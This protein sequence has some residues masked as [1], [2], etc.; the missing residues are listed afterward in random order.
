MT[1]HIV[2][3]A[4]YK[5][6]QLDRLKQRRNQL[7]TLCT[8]A[9]L[10]GTILL[11]HE[12]INLFVA[13]CRHGI[14]GLLRELR[15][16]P[17]LADL[18][19]KESLSNYQPFNRMLVRLKQEIIAFGVPGIAPAQATSPKLSAREL[20][21]WL[22]EGRPLTLLDVR[23]DYEVKLGTFKQAQPIGV[24]HF[25]DFPEAVKKLPPEAKQQPLVMFCTGGIRCEK[26]GPLMEREGFE[27]VYQ[28]DGGILKYFEECGGAHYEGDCFVFDQRVTVDCQ[29]RET[30][31][32]QC[33][34]C[35]ASLSEADQQ[36]EKYVVGESC[37]Y[38]FQTPAEK[39][40]AAIAGR[41]AAI[42]ALCDP[43]PGSV[44]YDNARPLNV[45][46]R[47]DQMTLLDFLD[48]FHPQV[49]RE[50]WRAACAAGAIVDRQG[51][52][53]EDR[54]VRAGE[55]FDHLQPATVE[56]DVNAD[57]QILHEDDALVVVNKPAPLPMHPS[58]R[59]HRNTL[60]Y[61]LNRV[62]EP[63]RL[64]A[65]HRLDANTSG[66]VIFSRTR[67]I[68]ARVQPQF[69]SG[70]VA[71]IYVA[72]IA[73]HPCDDHF[74]ATVPI[75]A[76]PSRTG[77]RLPDVSGSPARTEFRVLRRDEDGTALLDVHPLTGRTNQI[78]VHLWDLGMPVVGDPVYLSG[79]KLGDTQ[80]VTTSCTPLCLHAWTV[81]LQHPF[82]NERVEFETP[83]PAWFT[84]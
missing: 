34:A 66:V 62:Y 72:R 32:K 61:I 56:P 14:D 31:T 53:G 43:L 69:E 38:C 3:I 21:R 74:V 12:G 23:N 10:K 64:R 58:G 81:A 80:T 78:R 35:Q 9:G 83:L 76:S 36:S 33:F 57:I 75:S 27:Q 6:V 42:R 79:R 54:I 55:R 5:F 77:A 63:L 11:S 16:D 13:G 82:T 37:P 25:R 8:E 48:A 20:K 59:F 26:A 50:A 51:P 24:D 73:G 7:R 60:D 52:V 41:H 65:A 45:P 67:Q 2:N 29:L 46:L 47:F 22:D 4:A 84:R 19:V 1:E 30:P 17:A 18:E 15:S 68:A 28:L 49:G 39:M 40:A 44:P 70:D 71:K